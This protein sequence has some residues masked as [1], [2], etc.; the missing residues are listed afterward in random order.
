MSNPI[1]RRGFLVRAAGVSSSLA[2]PAG[3][4]AVAR[5]VVRSSAAG[6]PIRGQVIKRGASGF[7][8]AAHVYN[9][10]F[11]YVLPS[12]VAR[13]LDAADVRT[14][15]RWGV[16]QG[17]PLRARSGGHS[18]AG[19]S[20]LSGGMVLDL[21]NLRSVNVDL[22]ARTATVG[23]GAQLIDVYA[24]LAARGVTIP[25]GSCPSVGIAGH[26]L[27]GGMG[28][29]GRQFGLTADNLL[30][31]QIVTADGRLL[32][33]SAR[34]NPDLYW[35]L[36]GGGGGN[37]GVVTSFTFRVHAV[38]RTVAWFILSWPASRGADALAAWQAWAPHARN[39]LTSIFHLNS[40]GARPAEVTGQY[41]GPARDLGGL[42]APLTAVGQASVRTGDLGYLQ[43]QLFWAGCSTISF[44][45]CHT[46]GTRPGG[47]LPRESFQAKSDYVANPL[48]A[49]ARQALV[50]AAAARGQM[51]GSG[52]ILFDS[53]GGA[54]NQIAPAAT[55]F[56]HRKVLFCIQYLTYNGG[57]SWLQSIHNR[58]RPYVTGGAY[59]NYTDPGLSGWQTAYYGSNY[60]RLL[61]IR[62]AV[63]PHHYFNFPQAIGR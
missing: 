7:P 37:F 22:R 3:A 18:Y 20:T 46:T 33:V 41:F 47:T 27:G 5:A 53:Y 24:A 23:A 44:T 14:A 28:L 39:Q 9:T 57:G 15:V 8:D 45:A 25:A 10:R 2:L 34:Q 59:F 17:V 13:P 62:R 19:Y 21:R 43:A 48:P 49:S 40:A 36:R 51:S 52:A 16:A 26:A 4:G 63:D 55:A 30:S 31:A 6:P 38:P 58:M 1:D 54:I 61:Q 29:A 32:T 50:Q 35:A 11:D 60:R 42:L 12:W 56:V